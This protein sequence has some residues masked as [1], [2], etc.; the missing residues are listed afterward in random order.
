MREGATGLGITIRGG[1][2]AGEIELR[3]ADIGGIAVHVAQRILTAAPPGAVIVS[4]TVKDLVHGS[5][6][7]F[8]DVGTRTLKGLD[9]R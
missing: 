9:G 4:S 1:I 8:R 6:I 3:D 7:D 5:G 2:H